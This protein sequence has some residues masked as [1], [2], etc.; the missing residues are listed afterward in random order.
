MSS[1]HDLEIRLGS[2][3]EI[4]EIMSA[5]KNLS[6]MEVHKLGRFLDNQRRVIDSIAAAAAD[7]LQFHRTL[8]PESV[9]FRD[10][11]LLV[12]S[13]RGFC[14]DFN[15]A[16]VRALEKH[17]VT[18]QEKSIVV[19]GA[20]LAT[21]L[22]G[23]ARLRAAISGASVAEEIDGVLVELMDA[24]TETGAQ[25]ASEGPLRLTVLHHQPGEEQVAMTLLQALPPA[26]LNGKRYSHAPLLY[27]DPQLFLAGLI[28]Q[29]LFAGLHELLY[30]SLLAENQRRM[31]HM[32]A[33]VRRLEETC[34][35][36]VR[37]RNILRQ[38]EITE[39]I[40]VIMLSVEALR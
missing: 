14:G 34:A 37:T 6:L 31:Q 17:A 11:Y 1:R 35:E 30:S 10:F 8:F 20:K 16:L 21:K 2:L 26:P 28:E 25:G 12:G 38:E 39:E 24:L 9:T 22:A 3:N 15:E 13:E 32:D 18:A 4:K 23:D 27:L 19:V 5:M 36:L 7:L 29:Y 33:A 40:E